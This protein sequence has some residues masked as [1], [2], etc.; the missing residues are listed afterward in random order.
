MLREQ[1]LRYGDSYRGSFNFIRHL[2]PP[3]NGPPVLGGFFVGI[4]VLFVSTEARGRTP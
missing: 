1:H 3:G 2:G 4:V